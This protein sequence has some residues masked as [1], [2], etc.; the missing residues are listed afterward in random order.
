VRRPDTDLLSTGARRQIDALLAAQPEAASWLG[1]LSAVLEESAAPPWETMARATR[2]V[3]E[4]PPAA[5]LLSGAE[6][7]ADARY[8][9]RWLRQVLLIAGN[10]GPESA[11]LRGVA[12]SRDLASLAVLE[13]AINAEGDRLDA[14]AITLGAAPEALAV[15]A[16]LA[17]IPLL[18]A[19]RRRFGA[20]VAL[21][22]SE[23]YCPVCGDWPLLAE[24]RGLE[25]ARRLRCGRCGSDWAQ[26]GVRCPYCDVTGHA[27]RAALV[28]EADGEARRIEIC[29]QCHGYL[30]SVSTLRAWAGDEIPLADM[31]TVDLDLAALSR[32]YERP[33][34]RPLEPGVTVVK[35]GG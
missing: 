3:L 34:P 14:A 31:A 13:M 9:E 24:Q 12:E 28:P 29:H 32:E 10:A 6:I 30:K 18:Q 15:A 22:W 35:G 19:I 25:R 4:R 21:H 5:P 17:G 2:L 23:G 11:S 16:G 26:P 33:G 20:A 7:P 1:V 27:A 8:V